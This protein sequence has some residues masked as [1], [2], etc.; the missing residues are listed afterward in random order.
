MLVETHEVKSHANPWIAPTESERTE[1]ISHTV[2]IDTNE[3][4][5]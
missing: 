4:D 1:L 3:H 2:H 5:L